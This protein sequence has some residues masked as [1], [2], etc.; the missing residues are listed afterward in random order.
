MNQPKANPIMPPQPSLHILLVED[1][2][3]DAEIVQRALQAQGMKY[4]LW[5]A[6]D[7]IEALQI[8][9]GEGGRQQIPRP[10]LILLDLNLPRM[11]GIE[12]LQVLRQDSA[13]QDSTVLVLTTSE[14]KQ[15]KT[16]AYNAQV[17]GYFV[18]S[19]ITEELVG[20]IKQFDIYQHPTLPVYGEK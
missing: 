11:N 19:D 1:D 14:R 16:A 9:R 8:L 18:K 3:I 5:I 7:G 17:A 6:C 12:F 13:L 20:V 10:Y 2:E 15:D 4:P